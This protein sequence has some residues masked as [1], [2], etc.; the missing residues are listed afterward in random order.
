M[1]GKRQQI[2]Y[3]LALAPVERGVTPLGSSQGTEPLV[4]KPAPESPA[5]TEQLMEEV[6]NRE[7]LVRAWK[8]VRR[9]QG[10]A[11]VDGMTIDDARDYLREHWPS[12]RSQLLAGTYQPQPVKRVEIPKP[13]GGVRKLGVPSVVDRLIQQALLQVLQEQWDPTFS[14]HSYGFRRAL[15]PSGGGP[16]AALRCRGLQRCGRP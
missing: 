7:N 13:D 12:I 1:S 4:A 9:N 8:R 6:C 14:G 11:G 2:Q 16:S 5:V 15:G 10:S 3:V